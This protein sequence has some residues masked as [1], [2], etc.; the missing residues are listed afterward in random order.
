MHFLSTPFSHKCTTCLAIKSKVMPIKYLNSS[1]KIQPA[2][3]GA[4]VAI[5]LLVSKYSATVFIAGTK[6]ALIL[7]DGFSIIVYVIKICSYSLDHLPKQPHI[8]LTYHQIKPIGCL[9]DRQFTFT[10]PQ[11][12]SFLAKLN[13]GLT[14]MARA[15]W[16]VQR[17]VWPDT[18][19]VT[20]FG[21]CESD[22][23]HSQSKLLVLCDRSCL[24][25]QELVK[26]TSLAVSSFEKHPGRCPVYNTLRRYCR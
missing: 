18:R 10:A 11:L 26:H 25:R 6:S 23:S 5:D 14:C 9:V 19:L 20:I 7:V 16:W 24:L 3:S 22:V 8:L 21:S 17:F 1:L 15:T 13:W 12:L 2:K 4:H